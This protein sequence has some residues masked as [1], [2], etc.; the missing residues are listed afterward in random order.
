VRRSRVLR[1]ALVA[2]LIA[3]AGCTGAFA[4]SDSGTDLHLDDG[5]GTVDGI[6]HD[7]E[8]NISVEDGLNGTERDLLVTRAMARIETVRGLPFERDVDVEVITREQYRRNRS[9]GSSDETHAAWNNQVWRAMF[10]VGA[11]R[12][13]ETVL[14]ETLG[15]A[16]LG[17]YDVGEDRIV[18]VSDADKPT[19]S[20]DTLVH[21][22]V[23]ALQD[24]HFGL[25]DRPETQ[26]AQL[27]RRGVVEGEAE[28]VPDLYFERCGEEW[29]CIRP[30][31]PSSTDVG[32]ANIGVL[33]ILSTP[34]ATGPGFVETI[35]DRG[36]WAAVDDLYGNMP[37]STTQI[38]HPAKYPD[39]RPVDVTV[40]D[41]SSAGW[42]RF[43]H[44][45][46]GDRVGE[47]SLNVMLR[48]NGV[49]RAEGDNRYT[50]PVTDG[51]RGDKLV[52]Y[53]SGDEFGYVWK[54]EWESPD[55]AAVFTEHYRE[56]LDTH[57]AV[58][59]GADAFLVPDGPFAGAY[60]V[61]RDGTTVRIVNA[62][63]VADL[64]AIH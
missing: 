13:V 10:I 30:P 52:P 48:E 50:H 22:L 33:R 39:E 8:L 15:T 32:D 34:Y 61:H 20:K 23:H 47:A 49:I 53:R 54:L 62:P 56:L 28:L 43:D 21:E 16:V 26:D 63:T 12:D 60:R 17:F 7:D 59:R 9:G 29:S 1:L 24:Q 6:A 19:I 38:L 11:D 31:A 27:A 58:E 45:P 40:P 36:G 42:S 64:S 44:D 57:D 37:V 46:V 25:D 41:R 3:L 35:R 5:L 4:P 2:C 14:D 55:A 51:W 18:I